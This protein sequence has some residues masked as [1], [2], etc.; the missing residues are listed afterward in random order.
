MQVSSADMSQIANTQ[1]TQ[2]AQPHEQVSAKEAPEIAAQ[3]TTEVVS[4]DTV[5][6]SLQAQAKLLR[7][8]GVSIAQIARELGLDAKTINGY[9]NTPIPG[10]QGAYTASSGKPEQASAVSETSDTTPSPSG[11]PESKQPTT[12]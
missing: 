10:P 11:T 5:K 9:L 3:Q 7:K 6:L 8:Q 1:S 4:G 2:T 12:P